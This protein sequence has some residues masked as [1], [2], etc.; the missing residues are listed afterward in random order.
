MKEIYKAIKEN[1]PHLAESTITTYLSCITKVANT[2]NKPLGTP[3]ELIENYKLILDS[4][5]DWTSSLRKTK[6]SA[7]IVAIDTKH[8]NKDNEQSAELQEAL[9]AYRNQLAL[10]STKTKKDALK[11]ELTESQKENYISWDDVMTK[12]NQM[13]KR[14]MP[15]FQEKNLD[16][17]EF[18][19]LQDFIILSC[20]VLIPPRRSQDYCNFKI[21]DI[22][23]DTD[24][25]MLCPNKKKDAKFIF[26]SYKNATRLGSQSIPI[27]NELKK[28][29]LLWITKNPYNYLIV[30][31]LGK[32]ILQ[33]KLASM[34]NNIFGKKISSSML[35]HIY[36]THEFGN[37]DLERLQ[38][39]A[40]AMGSENIKT[41]LEYVQKNA[42]DLDN[43]E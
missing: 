10:D 41:S 3:L 25:F 20:Y 28:L 36:L 14:A 4:L 38:D 27:P 32:Q 37:V 5:K 17:K 15:L 21:R 33:S 12:Y 29:I 13:K 34:L 19:E 24:N 42:N 6:I 8:I 23:E 31:R 39:T 35:R 22:N 16:K 2:I 1:R 18:F 7:I 11:Q 9:L 40:N 26:N 30:N 43:T